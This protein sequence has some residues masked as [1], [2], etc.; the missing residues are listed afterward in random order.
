MSWLERFVVP[1][2]QRSAFFRDAQMA[3]TRSVLQGLCLAIGVQL[4]LGMGGDSSHAA[5]MHAGPFLGLTVSLVYMQLGSRLGPMKLLLISD[6]LGAL[7]LFSVG[8]YATG[9]FE[10]ALPLAL[11]GTTAQALNA[12]GVPL[13]TSTYSHIYPAAMRGRIVSLTRMVHGL[14]G[15]VG[16]LVLGNVLEARPAAVSIIFPLAGFFA[17]SA[18]WRVS[19]MEAL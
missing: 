8:L 12:V 19:R 15:L 1:A 13:I 2:D 6:G 10:G 9:A 5:W 18:V 16:L 7:S 14:A 11:A 4:V 17:L 3:A